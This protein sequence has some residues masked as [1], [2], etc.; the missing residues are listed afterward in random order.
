MSAALDLYAKLTE[1]SGDKKRARLIVDAFEALE[2]RFL[3]LNDLA[4]H[5]R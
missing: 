3:Q 1:T 5:S 2:A 4:T